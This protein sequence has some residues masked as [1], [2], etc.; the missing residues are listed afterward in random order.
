MSEIFEKKWRKF[1]KRVKPFRLV[2]FTQFVLA[3]GSLATGKAHEK[4]DFDV[5]VGVRPGRIFTNR[6]FA[7]IIFGIYGY[8]RS[9]TDHK[10]D[11]SDKIC[12]SHFVTPAS[13]KLEGPYNK[14]WRELYRSLIPVM[15]NEESLE[16]FFKSND[17][18]D[19]VRVYERHEEYLGPVDS[20]VKRIVE[21]ILG[22][23]FGD[24]FESLMESWQVSRIERG[25]N[26]SLGYKPKFIYSSEELRFHVDTRR[27]EEMLEK[28]E[29]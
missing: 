8:R 18:V 9:G 13:Y 26:N 1:I 16:E 21:K 27:I 10:E 20:W 22:G 23:K 5:I 14:Y 4:S 6:F 17:W 19:P 28:G 29:V 7:H 24:W 12:L 2:P 25:M 11:A 3:A 15:G